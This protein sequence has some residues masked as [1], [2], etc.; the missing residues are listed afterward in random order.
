[1]N[2][3]N[4]IELAQLPT[5]SLFISDIHFGVLPTEEDEALQTLV[6]ELFEHALNQGYT[7]FLLGDIFDYWMEVGSAVPTVAKIFRTRLAELARKNPI[8][9]VSGNHD[10]WTNGYF[11]RLGIWETKEG[12]ITRDGCLLAHGDGFKDKTYKLPRPFKHQLL[13]NPLFIKLF[14]RIYGK[15]KAWQKMQEYSKASTLKIKDP[16]VEIG[17]LNGWAKDVIANKGIKLV[18][19]GHDH[20]ARLITEPK[21]LFLNTGFFQRDK[22][23]GVLENSVVKLLKVDTATRNWQVMSERSLS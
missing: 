1:M 22:T 3:H 10:N 17:R 5:K 8:Y 11:S 21:G 23:F 18:V 14:L 20:Q 16:D 15:E 13:R 19:C 2:A 6:I 4:W 12:V 7:L 9:M